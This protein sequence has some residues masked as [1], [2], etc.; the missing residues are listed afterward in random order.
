MRKREIVE[1]RHAPRASFFCAFLVSSFNIPKT[2]RFVKNTHKTL[3]FSSKTSVIKFVR[4]NIDNRGKNI[5]K[6][7]RKKSIKNK[8]YE[9]DIDN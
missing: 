3:K 8:G 6:R 7:S 5:K 9:Y 1:L 2:L 4:K